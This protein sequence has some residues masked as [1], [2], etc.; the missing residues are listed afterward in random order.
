MARDEARAGLTLISPSLVIVLVVVVLPILWT[1]M[2]AFQRI[3]LLNL[4]SAGLFGQYTLANF[5]D[6]LTSPGF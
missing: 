2:L 4:R 6:V 3:R 5:Q 1:I